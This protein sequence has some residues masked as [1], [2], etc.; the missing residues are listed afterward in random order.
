MT[1]QDRLLARYEEAAAAMAIEVISDKGNFEGG[2]CTVQER[3][4]IVLNRTRPLEQR[5]RIFADALR[6]MGA[7]GLPGDGELAE[8][9]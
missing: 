5:L 2:L 7:K 6:S 9:A 3:P 4:R 1:R 8:G